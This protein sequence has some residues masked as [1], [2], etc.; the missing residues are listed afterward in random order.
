MFPRI[1]LAL[2]NCF[3]SKRWAAPLEWMQIARDCDIHYIEASADNECDPLYTPPDALEDWRN[4]VLSAT[5]A[6]GVKVANLYSGHG[7]YAT[8]GLAH[9]DKRVRDHIQHR[10]LEPMIDLARSLDAGLGFFCHAFSQAT[11]A[12]PAQYAAAVDDLTR[13]LGEL[14]AYAQGVG[15]SSLS[16]EQMY[17]P[18]QIPW[19]IHGAEQIMREA[20]RQT[21]APLYITLDTGHQVGQQHFQRPSPNTQS[22]MLAQP[23]DGDLYAWLRRLGGYSPIIHLQQTDGTESKHKPFTIANNAKGIVEPRRVLQALYEAYTTPPQEGLPPRCES[24]YLTLELFSATMDK[25]ES[26]LSMIRESAAYWRQFIPHDGVGL[27]ALIKA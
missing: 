21:N 12:D 2:D 6:T 18:H 3:A 14:A 13:R 1:Y 27:D 23:E 8:L 9:P 26:I 25:P 22:Y 4:A 19:T 5:Q 10:W 16:V 17:T 24:I 15:L 20:F 11:L 7:T